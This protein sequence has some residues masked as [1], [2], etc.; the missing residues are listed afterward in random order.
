MSYCHRIHPQQPVY[1][2]E[3]V[4]NPWARPTNLPNLW[5]S[6]RTNLREP[7]WIELSWPQPQQLQ[8]VHILFDSMLSFHFSQ[9]WGGYAQN[10]IPS[11]VA[12]YRLM[13]KTGSQSWQT[14]AEVS[15]NYQRHSR[16][17]FKPTEVSKIR[18]EVLKT[19]GLN[20]VQVYALRVYV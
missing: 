11:L 5:A 7:E 17:S 19:H 6:T 10:A 15:G 8:T 20:R 13:A 16:H 2:P 18:L 4:I 3:N 14:L 9:S 12:N 1:E